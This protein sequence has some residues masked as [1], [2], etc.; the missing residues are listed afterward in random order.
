M[1]WISTF[2]G[3]ATVDGR[4]KLR[5]FDL[6]VDLESTKSEIV[7]ASSETRLYDEEEEE[8]IFGGC[9]GTGSGSSSPKSRSRSIRS[10]PSSRSSLVSRGVTPAWPE[11]AVFKLESIP[12]HFSAFSMSNDP[13]PTVTVHCLDY[14]L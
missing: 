6:L 12:H 8:E 11:S 3:V 7:M 4:G 1:T 9:G 2:K 10:A 14:I 13:L 5:T